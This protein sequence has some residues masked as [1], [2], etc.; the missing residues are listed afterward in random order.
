MDTRFNNL[1]SRLSNI[2]DRL[3]NPLN[4]PDAITQLKQ[5][6]DRIIGMLER[7]AIRDTAIV[8]FSFMAVGAGFVG[9][10][11]MD[12]PKNWP[13]ILVG[14]VMMIIGYCGIHFRWFTRRSA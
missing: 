7:A 5:Q 1:D 3:T 9:G 2:E 14:A 10:S 12:M 13:P 11:A 4:K 8:W 6:L